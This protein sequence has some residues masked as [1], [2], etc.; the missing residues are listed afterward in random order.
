VAVEP[1][2]ERTIHQQVGAIQDSKQ[3]RRADAHCCHGSNGGGCGIPLLLLL[4][5]V[6]AVVAVVVCSILGVLLL[7]LLLLGLLWAEQ[8]LQHD[9]VHAPA[10]AHKQ[11]S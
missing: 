11:G 4:L 3:A 10:G 7:L 9:A 1:L 5:V 6:G 2:K 8:C